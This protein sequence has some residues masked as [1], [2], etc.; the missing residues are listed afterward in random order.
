MS[1]S[2]YQLK[3]CCISIPEPTILVSFEERIGISC[4]N[5]ELPWCTWSL[6]VHNPDINAYFPSRPL[7]FVLLHSCVCMTDYSR[8]T[9]TPSLYHLRFKHLPT[10]IRA[11]TNRVMLVDIPRRMYPR[12]LE[13]RH[14]SREYRRPTT[15]LQLPWQSHTRHKEQLNFQ[16]YPIQS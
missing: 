13:S 5:S 8:E 9:R 14:V 16:F 15:S 3:N 11:R 2:G 7:H 10:G 6:P 1:F 12:A 4:G